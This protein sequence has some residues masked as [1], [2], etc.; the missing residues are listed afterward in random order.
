MGL[1]EKWND[2]RSEESRY[3]S[4]AKRFQA[5]NQDLVDELDG[6]TEVDVDAAG[7]DEE[8]TVRCKRIIKGRQR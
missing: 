1:L 7:L 6:M 3:V 8:G 5:V 2:F 4:Y